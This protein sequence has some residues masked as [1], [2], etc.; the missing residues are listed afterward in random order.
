RRAAD[1]VQTLPTNHRSDGPLV[2]ALQVVT[3]GAALGDP[4][5]AVHPIR[6]RHEESRLA[7]TPHPAPLR[8]RH[9]RRDG[10]PLNP[11][12]LVGIAGLR[13]RIAAALAADVAELL[14][15]GATFDGRAVRAGD[16][17]ILMYSLKQA[18]L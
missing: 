11:S 12:G 15:S 13:R 6:A 9:V 10:L 8:I 4:A 14:A 1:T 17:A 2:D 16:V 7:G 3:R 5:I 18:D